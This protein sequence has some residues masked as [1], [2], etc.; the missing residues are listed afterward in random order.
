MRLNSIHARILSGFAALILLQAGVA[1]AV[2]RAENHVDTAIAA[3]TAADAGATQIVAARAALGAVRLRLSTFVASGSATDRLQVDAALVEL[4]TEVG[5]LA[6]AGGAEQ[7]A[8]DIEALRTR[9]NA[10]FAALLSRRDN[11]ARLT[12]GATDAENALW[13]L[14]Q[15][16][17]AAPERATVEAASS[18]LA[19]AL[20]PLLFTQRYALS[21]D[22]QDARAAVAAIARVRRL[23]AGLPLDERSATPR[24]RRLAG[25][26]AA[27]M[28]ALQPAIEALGASQ[29]ARNAQIA[30]LR[31]AADRAEQAIADMNTRL[32]GARA[33]RRQ[34][35]DAARHVVRITVLA[36]AAASGLIGIAL[37]LLVGRSIAQPIGR[38]AQAMRRLANGALDIDVPDRTRRDEIGGMAGA[39]QFFK[40][41]LIRTDAMAAEQESRAA[42]A[43]AAQKALTNRTAD[44]FEANVGH[45]IAALSSAAGKL[46][47]TARGMSD[48]ASQTN[49]KA[50]EV[51]VA[52][53]SAS[54]A[55][56]TVAAA[57]EELTAS[58]G[59]IGRQVEASSRIT[60]QAV[61]DAQRTD[62]IVRKLAEGAETIGHVIGLI[63]SIASQTNLLALNATIEAARAG[64]AGKGFAVVA[65]EVK[66]LA[67]QTTR[68][69]GEVGAQIAAIQAATGEAVAA[70]RGIAATIGEVSAIAGAIAAAVAQQS[71]ATTQIARN[72]QATAQSAQRVTVTIGGVSEAAAQTGAAAGDVLAAAGDLSRQAAQLTS[73]VGS[74]IASVRA[75]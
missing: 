22:E 61:G 35:S 62:A 10:V 21:M 44:R 3:A 65:S 12:Q 72:V 64:E 34:D 47:A 5:K 26:V 42:A 70:V 6:G 30:Q 71:G 7:L 59:E 16:A 50:S 29:A 40:D 2:W 37:T 32:A 33:E 51:A 45:L 9:L 49:G 60:G 28:D 55:V 11:L 41:N 69:T 38:L 1:A 24:L 8:A 19:G 73:E 66:N 31:T 52:A 75:A 17:A 54:T 58:I 53:Q 46:E 43:A 20:H 25:I 67:N 18:V 13:A 14:S 27:S 48:T 57:A 23:L 74:F 39:V 15:A 63:T 4:Q 68:A 56:Q 36:A